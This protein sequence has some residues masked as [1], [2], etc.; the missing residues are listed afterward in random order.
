M[1]FNR[2][3]IISLT[4]FVGAF[5]FVC[6]KWC[7]SLDDISN[8]IGVS[9][10]FILLV[11]FYY[12]QKRL[13]STSYFDTIDGIYAAYT[14]PTITA[15][16]KFVKA[17][18]IFN[19]RDTDDS[20][21]FKGELDYAE[22]KHWTINGEYHCEKVIEA[23]YTFLGQFEFELYADKTRHPFRPKENRTYSG[24]LTIVDRLDFQF[25][26]YKIED[27]VSAE[28]DIVHYREM[29]TM[30]FTLI[31]K[32]R[33]EFALLPDTFTLYKSMGF[34]FEP[35]SSVKWDIFNGNTLSDR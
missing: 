20:G 23:H 34:G 10:P 3:L 13:W 4:V 31:K 17:G 15:D 30:K 1:S 14:A 8:I 5:L 28:Y 22:L 18:V 7:L 2:T 26:D 24:T 29:Q 12:S 19:I 16:G 35:Y 9:T 27:Y 21:Y 33:P 25:E 6:I 11:W 32:Y